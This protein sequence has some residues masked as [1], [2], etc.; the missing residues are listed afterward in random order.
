LFRPRFSTDVILSSAG[1]RPDDG[2]ALKSLLSR[3]IPYEKAGAV[4]PNDLMQ[5]GL[6]GSSIIIAAG[7]MALILPSSAAIQ[8][9]S[10]YL[11]LGGLTANLD[12]LMGH[13]ASPALICGGTL[14][15]FDAGL[16]L[17]RTSAPWRYAV[18][19]QAAVGGV[20]G[21]FCTFFL[22]LI[23]LNL[24]IWAAIFALVLVALGT[25]FAAMAGAS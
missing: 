3:A 5:L 20:G 18:V 4:I 8:H 22:V 19:A 10:F 25:I 23:V 7:L 17:F 21:A 2:S 1:V 9:S 14:L 6:F 15:V 13:A 11:I 12:S 24:I 16:M